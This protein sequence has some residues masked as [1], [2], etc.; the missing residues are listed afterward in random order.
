M[1]TLELVVMSS[2]T[3]QSDILASSAVDGLITTITNAA[4]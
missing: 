1:L 3:V 2:V 4:S